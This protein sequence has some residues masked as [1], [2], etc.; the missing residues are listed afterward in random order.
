MSNLNIPNLKSKCS[1]S[2]LELFKKYDNNDYML[3]RIYTHIVNY[4]PNT[5]DNEF[6]NYESLDTIILNDQM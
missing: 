5:L 1:D 2:L 6:N 3:Q 4:L